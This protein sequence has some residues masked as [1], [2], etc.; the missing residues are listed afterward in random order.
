MQ[1]IVIVGG[2]IAAVR[3]AVRLRARGSTDDILILSGE[4]HLPYDRPPLSKEVLRAARDLP[5][6]REVT[7]L[8]AAGVQL[9]LG[10]PATAL[11]LERGVVLTR[12]ET[13]GY[14]V[15]VIATGGLPRRL[16]SLAGHVLRTWDDAARLRSMMPEGS[17][18][19]IIGAGLIGCEVAA[20][21]RQLGAQVHL[22]DTL[23][24]PL[25]RVVGPRFGAHVRAV[26][27][28]RGVRFHL[29]RAVEAVT[30]AGIHLDGGELIEVDVVMQAVGSVPATGWLHGS[31]LAVGDG[32]L[33]DDD[34]RTAEPGVF[35]VGDVAACSARRSEHWTSA[36]H[37]ADRVAAAILGQPAPPDEVPYWWS[38]QYDVKLQGLGNYRP[39]DDVHIGPWGP[40]ARPVGLFSRDGRLTGAV[41]MSSAGVVMRLR[42]DI[43][44]RADIA[45]VL[46]RLAS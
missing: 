25:V 27:E 29:S 37:Q 11:D 44:A 6:L 45:G 15:L 14:D 2:G 3:T 21:A 40:K 24:V 36:V 19:G 31:G 38:D 13:V 1:R 8:T 5:A 28:D 23:D 18:V 33:C 17:R 7:E 35:A 34:G 42:D 26:H 41:G 9:R 30:T 10:Q 12:D 46:E 32:V 16:P 20:S 22:V 4:E 43:A 39:D